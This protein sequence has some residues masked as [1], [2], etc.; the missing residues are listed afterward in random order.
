ML[1]EFELQGTQLLHKGVFDTNGF[2]VK[3]G[4][5]LDDVTEEVTNYKLWS[6][7][8]FTF[9][10]QDKIKADTVFKGL[11]SA[12]SG[13]DWHYPGIGHIREIF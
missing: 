9:E 4:V 3:Y 5:D 2:W 11:V 7:F 10:S 8:S 1:L 13:N 6:Y 12:L